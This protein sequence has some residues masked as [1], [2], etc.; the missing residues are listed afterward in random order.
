M[1]LIDEI[2][3]EMVDYV[4]TNGEERGDRTG[5][6]TL[7]VFGYQYKYDLRSFVTEGP[8]GAYTLGVENPN[9]RL[10]GLISSKKVLYR[11]VVAELLAFLRGETTLA[12]FTEAESLWKYWADENGNLG[13]IYGAQMVAWQDYVDDS[14]DLYYGKGINQIEVL[15]NELKNNPTSRRHLVSCWNVAELSEMCLVPCHVMFQ[16]YVAGGKYLDLQMYQRSA[17]LVLGVPFNIASYCTL[18]IMLAR[19][20]NLT[21]RYFIHSFGDLHIYGSHLNT[22]QIQMNRNIDKRSFPHLEI[23]SDK[24][25][26]ELVNTNDIDA[27]VV[28]DYHPAPFLR[29]EVAV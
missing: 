23:Q 9:K 12:G 6:G 4:L 7:S 28:K 8:A 19:E 15:I 21:P 11:K 1:K 29:Y 17:D 10:I 26:W 2:Y 16:C 3:A 25:F 22:L 14:W 13:P 20:V 18:L 24:S 27:F 5:V